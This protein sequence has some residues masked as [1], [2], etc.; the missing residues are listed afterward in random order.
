MTRRKARTTMRIGS[1]LVPLGS[2]EYSADYK[3]RLKAAGLDDDTDGWSMDAKRL[4]MARQIAMWSNEWPGCPE[5]I[6]QRMRGCMA[7]DIHCTNV[8]K[9][10]EAE[11]A[12]NWPRVM[13]GLRRAIAKVR[14][15]RGMDRG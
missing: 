1:G 3:A 15:E 11:L 5:P 14:A 10:S 13:V 4:H 12:A 6:C 2:P 9:I 7:P 8:P